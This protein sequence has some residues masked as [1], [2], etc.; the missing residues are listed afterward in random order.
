MS[1]NCKECEESFNS[2]RSLH[3]HIKK[4]GLY[5][6]DYYVKNFNKKDKLTKELIPFKKY[7]QYINTDFLNVAN[8][9]KWCETAP[10]K[11]VKEYIINKFKQRA[12]D[13]ELSGAPPCTYLETAGMPTIDIC[14]EVFGSYTDACEQFGISPML[15]RQLPSQFHKNYKNT[16]IL[17][18]TRE[19]QPLEFK[20]SEMLKL[21]VG[22]YAVKGENFDY[23]FVDRKTYQDFCST[24]THGYNRFIKEIERCKSLE[25]FLFVVVEAPFDE[26]EDQN[27][28]N[29]KKFKLDYVFHQMREIQARYSDYCQ[30]VFSGSREYSIE[31]IP[32][33]LVLGKKL[34]RV[35]LQYFWNKH[36]IKNGLGNRKTKTKKRVQRYKP[37]VT[38]K[39]GI[40][41]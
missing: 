8:M 26:M 14:K 23:T 28:S 16:T 11:E 22:D 7:D 40:F 1:Y 15:S 2:L 41:R 3:A 31:L 36:I 18:D 25:S 19:Q 37:V 32:K 30:F 34:W 39:R 20:N 38:G 35:D 12:L 17:V 5:V 33:I 21:D 29:Y 9:R 27:K 10:R 13:K 6:G 24:V 4:H